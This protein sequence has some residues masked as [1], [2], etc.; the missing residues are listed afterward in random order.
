MDGKAVKVYEFRFPLDVFEDRIQKDILVSLS[1]KLGEVY[2]PVVQS[3]LVFQNGLVASCKQTLE[4]V[5]EFTKLWS[6]L[7]GH[8]G[9]IDMS[10][11]M[12]THRHQKY[13]GR[14]S[15]GPHRKCKRKKAGLL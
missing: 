2:L 14:Y 4:V 3:I 7:Y 6:A 1:V 12:K 5:G 11:E 10:D 8:H 9:V 15:R 13:S